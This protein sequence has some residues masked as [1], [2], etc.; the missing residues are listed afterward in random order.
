MAERFLFESP[1]LTEV[2][3]A[4]ENPTAWLQKITRLITQNYAIPI[5]LSSDVLNVEST[6]KFT[7]EQRLLLD[8]CAKE[9]VRT[10]FE[11]GISELLSENINSSVILTLLLTPITGYT[12]FEINLN[13]NHVRNSR[14]G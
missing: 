13:F 10:F 5:K 3:I 8:H 4:N 2:L 7:D 14:N 11:N 9:L 6:V 1:I 12:V